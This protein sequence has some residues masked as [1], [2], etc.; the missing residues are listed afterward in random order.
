M[1]L[2]PSWVPLLLSVVGNLFMPQLISYVAK[3]NKS[4]L[5][6]LIAYGSSAIVGGLSAWV[7]GDFSN[8]LY[9]SIIAGLTASQAAYQA[10]WKAKIQ[11]EAAKEEPPQV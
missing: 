10:Y 11:A 3:S 7:A 1:P 2:A 9:P 6:M 8:S 5:N 4:W